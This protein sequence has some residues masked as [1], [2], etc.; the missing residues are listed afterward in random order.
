[1]ANRRFRN[2]KKPSVKNDYN[3]PYPAELMAESVDTLKLREETA[4]LLQSAG[5]STLRD[6]AVREEKDFYRIHT[7]NKKNLLDVKNALR[8]KKV[9]IKPTPEVAPT[10]ENAGQNDKRPEKKQEQGKKNSQKQDN[11][12]KRN[13][14]ENAAKD[15][16]KDK[17]GLNAD[18]VM[19]TLPQ[20]P[21]RPKSVPVKEEH[22]IYVKV[23]KGGKWG[24]KDRNGKQV[25][26]PVY[27]EVFNYK[28]NVCCVEKDERFGYINREGE[29]IIPIIYDC[30]TSFSEG[31][32]CVYKREKCGYIDMNNETVVEFAFDAGTPVSDGECRVKRDGKWGEMHINKD[33]NGEVS[34]SEIRWIT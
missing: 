10:T 30:A 15:K 2:N 14:K 26:E 22:D 34:V 7:F 24:F 11:G 17:Y 31:Y 21:P 20:R 6:L 3:P 8:A 29:L 9:A 5:I 18:F 13:G 19:T 25:V 27:D 33:E 4:N 23:N 32:A 16:S 28:E 1:M 12:D